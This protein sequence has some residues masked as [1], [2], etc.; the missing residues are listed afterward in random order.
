MYWGA[1]DRH[2]VRLAANPRTSMPVAL[3]HKLPEQ[4][5]KEILN[6]D[7]QL[8]SNLDVL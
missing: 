8:R 3:W 5:R 7:A 4:T 2:Q 1:V 6:K